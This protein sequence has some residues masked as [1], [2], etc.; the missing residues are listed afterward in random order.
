MNHYK[1]V[2]IFIVFTAVNLFKSAHIDDPF[3]IAQAEWILGNPLKPLSGSINWMDSTKPFYQ[4]NN[5]PLV[6]YFLAIG[7][8]IF[9]E[10]IFGHHIF[11][12]LF[13]AGLI[14]FLIQIQSKINQ[15]NSHFWWI[16]FLSPFVIINQ[17]LMLEI[18][19]NFFIF[20][21]IYC[22]LNS[23]RS[24][25]FSYL[26]AAMFGFAFLTK[27]SAMVFFILPVLY[28][29]ETK[30]KSYLYSLIPILIIVSAW[31]GW[32]YLEIGHI[33]LFQRKAAI[34]FEF[35]KIL[36]LIICIGNIVLF[37]IYRIFDTFKRGKLFY[38]ML[39]IVLFLF[40]SLLYLTNLISRDVY[41]YFYTAVS[42][43]FGTIWVYDFI[44]T[45]KKLQTLNKE[46]LVVGCYTLLIL[47]ASP[48]IA[49][50]HFIPIILIYGLF[51]FSS[52]QFPKIIL[53]FNLIWTLLIGLADVSYS[54]FYEKMAFQISQKYQKHKIYTVGHNGWQYYSQKNQMIFY[55]HDSSKPKTGDV[56]I[57]PTNTHNQLID[58]NL[59][60]TKIESIAPK[61]QIIQYFIG[62]KNAPYGSNHMNF[63]PFIFSRE[64]VD[65]FKIYK[66][67]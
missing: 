3:Y 66:I 24:I 32:N 34:S 22:Y 20:G 51:A 14:Y 50:R 8:K 12:S 16:V 57:I 42:F 45:S 61:P 40:P 18:P 53:I 27:Y 67:N 23:N 4:E 6:S 62:R 30:I 41:F 31:F 35:E 54:L 49:T 9:G 15:S 44:R 37:S 33:H 10:N 65:T 46:M 17:N 48:F 39:F 56:F 21:G 38:W 28:W 63:V 59:S 29:F 52:Y 47:Y 36:S 25:K 7:I 55:D 1:L 5:P 43:I 2:L 64:P 58:S 19:L 11:Y 26:G 60:L 13:L